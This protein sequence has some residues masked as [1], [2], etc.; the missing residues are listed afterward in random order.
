MN[1]IDLL[2]RDILESQFSEIEINSLTSLNCEIKNF[3]TVILYVNIRSLNANIATLESYINSLI[4]KPLVIVCSETW[5]VT[6]P[7]L[8]KIDDYS[9]YYNNG[10]I[11]NAD[12]VVI[13]VRN[14]IEH[15]VEVI[16]DHDIFKI[17]N[18]QIKFNDKITLLISAVY[19]C[20]DL[21]ETKLIAT[22]K[23]LMCYKKVRHHFIIGDFNINI[24]NNDIFSDELLNSCYSAGF[25]PLFKTVTRPNDANGTCIDNMYVK[26]N[27]EIA[28]YKHEQL[29]TD[30]YPLIC[31]FNCDSIQSSPSPKLN[32]KIINNKKLLEIA[33]NIDWKK[34]DHISDPNISIDSL[35]KDIHFCVDNATFSPTKSKSKP[36]KLWMT[37]ALLKSIKHKEFLY[38][39]WKRNK[40]SD[41][42]KV[43]YKT[44]EKILQKVIKAAKN[45]YEI[46]KAKRSS[47]NSKKL[48]SYI[49]DKLGNKTKSCKIEKI[50]IGN[51][52]SF[53]T[54]DIA[55]EFNDFFVNIGKKLAN[56]I[57]P[58]TS[59]KVRLDPNKRN[60][61]CLFL[62]YTNSEEIS[63]VIGKLKNRSGGID[64]IHSTVL[65]KISFYISPILA[66]IFNICIYCGIWPNALKRADVVPVF[67]SG[68]RTEVNNYRPISIIS[69]IAKV[70]EKI[71]HVRISRFLI[72]SNR[73]NSKQFGFQQNKSS[74]HAL[75]EVCDSIYKGISDNKAVAATFIDLSKAFDTVDHQ[76]LFQKL[77]HE[78]V[79]GIAL[80]LMK[81]YL[82]ERKQKV[83]INNKHSKENT[84]ELGVPQGTVLGPLLF[85]IYIN[86]IFEN[87][88]LVFA[89]ADDTAVLS[90]ENTWQEVENTMNEYLMKLNDWFIYNKLTINVQKNSFIT[91]GCYS[92]SVPKNLN[93]N[94]NGTLISR[95]ESL[96]YLGLTLD[97]NLKWEYHINNLINKCRYFLY[98][99][100]KL[101]YLPKKVI[102]TIYNGYVF[103][104]LNYGIII[105][106]GAYP[107]ALRYLC[108]LQQTFIKLLKS[109]KIPTLDQL[110]KAKCILH[111]YNS[112]STQF[113]SS[114]SKTRNK[115]I[116]LPLYKKS[117]SQKNSL[118]T[119][120]NYFNKLPN[121]LKKLT[122]SN[123]N[124]MIKILQCLKQL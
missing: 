34:Y 57:Q 121:E 62:R 12:G 36:R 46:N 105:W 32:N 102:E 83:K 39:I 104:I 67:K 2:N 116:P 89:Y 5:T 66:E 122:V 97:Y 85:L 94:I 19:R 16:A 123:K 47:E 51:D 60:E 118:F 108:S 91:F 20:H 50:K 7:N 52:I 64:N 114:C 28:A 35:I 96:K 54:H 65:K 99:C 27:L 40:Q 55:N 53:D 112:L 43:E 11:N 44:Y 25:Y 87:C 106:G 69:N 93:I 81:S 24:L 30:H 70:F 59:H 107:T 119:A 109:E 115:S 111:H 82:S 1:T 110:Y 18:C 17:L 13:Y 88:P 15:T 95:K 23:K 73:I 77:Y 10:C 21:S 14:G 80:D 61:K 86:D 113:S 3:N 68:D 22:M 4:V 48:W 100:K 29:F 33:A 49:N 103:S 9:I 79:R 76:I 26:T 90:I 72:N 101:S 98:I 71:V 84:I 120:I 75:E 63:K 8:Y 124:K 37:S 78:G 92:D 74:V 56:N 6:N 38:N 45:N 42:L 58:Q 41:L 117:V 31:A